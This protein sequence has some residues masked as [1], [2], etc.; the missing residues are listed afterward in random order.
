VPPDSLRSI[1][2]VQASLDDIG[3]QIARDTK[4]SSGSL[5]VHH[6]VRPPQD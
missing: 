3:E 6:V 4:K 1:W 2:K 5:L